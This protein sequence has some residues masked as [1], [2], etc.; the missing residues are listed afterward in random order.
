MFHRHGSEALDDL[1]EALSNARRRYA[2]YY[3]LG[4]DEVDIGEMAMTITDWLSAESDGMDRN[5]RRRDRVRTSL[6]HADLPKLAEAGLVT[7]DRRDETVTFDGT[8]AQAAFVQDL[9]EHERIPDSTIPD[10]DSIYPG[11]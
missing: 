1:L 3:A 4:R 6:Y 8:D 7:V 5:V 2:L 11:V 9:L 10:D